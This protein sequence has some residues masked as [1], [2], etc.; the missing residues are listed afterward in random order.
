MVNDQGLYLNKSA[1]NFVERYLKPSTIIIFTLTVVNVFM[2]ASVLGV[3]I[4]FG[5]IPLLITTVD[6]DNSYYQFGGRGH[7]GWKTVRMRVTAYCP[8]SKCCGKHSDGVTASAHRIRR[9]DTFVAA[10]NKY[11]FNTRFIVPGYNKSKPVEVLDRGGAIKGNRL[12]VFFNSHEEARE[13]GLKY[14]DVKFRQ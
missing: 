11:A 7:D 1:E 4:E 2:L 3:G 12:D 9:G 10:D 8:C 5:E 13:W 6:Q 14:L